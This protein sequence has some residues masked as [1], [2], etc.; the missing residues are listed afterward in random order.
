MASLNDII[1]LNIAGYSVP[2]AGDSEPVIPAA[3]AGTI[4][5]NTSSGAL[6]VN[7]D[8]PHQEVQVLL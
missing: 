8:D 6:Q 3:P 1:S 5:V 7:T 4:E 2:D